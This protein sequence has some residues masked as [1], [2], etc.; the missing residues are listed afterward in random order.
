MELVANIYCCL[1][2]LQIH[3][4]RLFKSRQVSIGVA[5]GVEVQNEKA[6]G[7]LQL[8]VTR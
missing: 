6:S 5:F 2:C 1:N 7:L 3:N 8:L 4:S